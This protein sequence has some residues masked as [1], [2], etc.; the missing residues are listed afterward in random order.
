ML[1][2]LHLCTVADSKMFLSPVYL[3]SSHRYKF[4]HTN[5]NMVVCMLL[6]CIYI[7]PR[8]QRGIFLLFP[9]PR[10]NTSSKHLWTVLQSVFP[11]FSAHIHMIMLTNFTCLLHW[12]INRAIEMVNCSR[13]SLKSV[14]ASGVSGI[15]Q[16]IFELSSVQRG[17][18]HCVKLAHFCK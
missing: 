3:I 11:F 15:L 7:F 12:C 8:I 2:V 9:K 5:R 17:E 14:E 13:L 4:C 10:L 16:N 18:I 6:H 1:K